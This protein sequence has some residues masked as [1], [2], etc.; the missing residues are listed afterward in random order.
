MLNLPCMGALAAVGLVALALTQAGCT[1]GWDY[2]NVPEGDRC[3]PYDSH[4]ECASGL[5]CTVSSWQVANQSGTSY[6]GTPNLALAAGAGTNNAGEPLVLEFCPEN[7][8]CPVDSNGNLM[9]NNNPNCQPGC[10]GGAAS[11]CAAI[12]NDTAPYVGVCDFDGGPLPEEDAESEAGPSP[13]AGDG[14]TPSDAST[15]D[16]STS[17]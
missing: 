9:A 1:G 13:D 11:I 17:D 4:N 8:C 14:G 2:S 3:N 12:G 15:A 10:N 7:Y 16:A 5:A 6:L